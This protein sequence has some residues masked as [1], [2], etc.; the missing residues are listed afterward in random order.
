MHRVHK[1]FEPKLNSNVLAYMN[2]RLTQLTLIDQSILLK[3]GQ[4]WS[5]MPARATHH[6]LVACLLPR[7]NVG[8][9]VDVRVVGDVLGSRVVRGVT[10]NLALLALPNAD[11]VNKHV[12]REVHVSHVDSLEAIRHSQIENL[13]KHMNSTFTLTIVIGSSGMRRWPISVW[14]FGPTADGLTVHDFLPLAI[15]V[16]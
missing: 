10:A 14:S 2:S 5:R 8:V 15:H 3:M 1:P 6:R 12:V 13:G 16:M 4:R 7:R 11:V 9:V